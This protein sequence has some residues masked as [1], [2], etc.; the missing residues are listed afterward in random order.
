[1]SREQRTKPC[2][3]CER[4]FQKDPRNTW[5]Y[6]NR[7]KFCSQSCA[8]LEHAKRSSERRPSMFEAFY[9]RV[10]KTDGCWLWAGAL[11]KDGYGAFGYAGRMRRAARVSLALDGRPVPEGQHARHSCDNPRCVNP[12][13]LLPGTPKQN[14]D[15]KRS[16]HRLPK[17]ASAGAAKLAEKDVQEIRASPLS[18]RELAVRFGVSRSNISMIKSKRTW[19][20]VP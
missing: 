9:A 17:G 7:A 13:H 18:R 14:T 1:M 11:D 12:S 10:I 3:H 2:V 8:G 4:V 20:D 19:V 15:D 16:R 5:A 6:W